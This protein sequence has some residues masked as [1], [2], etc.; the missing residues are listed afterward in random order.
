MNVC[1]L[2]R[3]VRK[4]NSVIYIATDHIWRVAIKRK[5]VFMSDNEMDKSVVN[6]S[7]TLRG[8]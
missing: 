6:N 1:H 4:D 7:C 2:L 8:Y 5:S 3:Q